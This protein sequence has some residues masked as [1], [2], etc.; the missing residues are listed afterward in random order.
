MRQLVLWSACPQTKL[1]GV[2][3][4]MSGQEDA[5]GFLYTSGNVR[6]L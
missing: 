2:W 4:E 5:M 3:L 6:I 1:G